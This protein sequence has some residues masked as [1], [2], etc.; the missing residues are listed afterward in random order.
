MNTKLLA[1]YSLKFHPFH[2]DVPTE[3]LYTTPVVDEEAVT[4]IGE[5]LRELDPACQTITREGL[6]E[7]AARGV[8]QTLKAAGE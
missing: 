1:L 4:A 6:A 8:G 7:L 5:A 2:A 3:A